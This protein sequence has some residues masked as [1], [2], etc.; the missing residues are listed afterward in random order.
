MQPKENNTNHI[1]PVIRIN[2]QKNLAFYVKK[3]L[4]GFEKTE[5][6]ELQ[7]IG[8]ATGMLVKVCEGMVRM[9]NSRICR[10]ESLGFYD[11]KQYKKRKLKLVAKI[12]KAGT[13]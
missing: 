2:S 4:E 12:R 10:L 6:V 7:G 13:E 11:R 3:C 9:H 8:N 1:I 5:Y